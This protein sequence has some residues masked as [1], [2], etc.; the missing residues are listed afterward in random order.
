MDARTQPS[1]DNCWVVTDGKAGMETQCLGLAEA[2]G[3]TPEVKRIQVT[4]P[5]RWL[6]PQ[7][8]RDPLATLGPKGHALAP[9]WPRILIA[10]G[11]QTIAPAIA[12]RRL[13][14]G[15][16]FVIQIQNPVL[17]PANFDA[18]VTPAHDRLEG[19]NVIATM[20]AMGRVTPARLA[21]AAAH[22]APRFAHLPRPLVAVL[23]GGNNKAFRMT[24]AVTR[25]LCRDLTAVARET[26]AG[27][28][29]T[30]S[31]RTGARNEAI[32]RHGLAELPAEIWDGQG[33]NPYFGLL[34][35]ADALVVTCDSVNMVSEAASTGKPLHIVDLKGYSPKFARFH[36]ALRAAGITRPFTGKLESWHYTPLAETD[37]AAREILSRLEVWEAARPSLRQIN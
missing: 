19:P 9:P 1:P 27:L 30:P 17:D 35:L 12:V 34:A 8:I 31:R 3:M 28:L 18:V 20:G 4:K 21:E 26:G 24:A 6:P 23:I 37:R 25:R 10:S 15:R 14:G 36:D 32:L 7:L 29:V 5:W 11:R 16:S 13:A 22:F 33:E 2:M